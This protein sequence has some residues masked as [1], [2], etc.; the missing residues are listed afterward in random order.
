MRIGNF[1][2]FFAVFSAWLS[3]VGW[4]L[5]RQVA[6]SVPPI[7]SCRHDVHGENAVGSSRK[8]PVYTT[9]LGRAFHGDALDVLQKIPDESVALAFTSPP[10]ALRRQKAYGNLPAAEYIEWF[11]PI[12]QQIHR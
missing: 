7:V 9:P 2:L 1:H 10:F 8:Q 11:W 5:N 6:I 12:A 3:Q 4:Q